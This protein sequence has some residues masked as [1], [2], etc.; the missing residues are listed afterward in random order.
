MTGLCVGDDN[1]ARL[2]ARLLSR[3]TPAQHCP[4]TLQAGQSAGA[5]DHGE[6]PIGRG[7]HARLHA[8]PGTSVH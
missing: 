1:P 3:G 7:G 2:E 8:R 6:T 5:T 4:R